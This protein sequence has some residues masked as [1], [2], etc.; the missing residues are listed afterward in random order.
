MGLS[1]LDQLLLAPLRRRRASVG[2]QAAQAQGAF[3][4]TAETELGQLGFRLAVPQ[5]RLLMPTVANSTVT[6]TSTADRTV[7]GR[8]GLAGSSLPERSPKRARI[9]YDPEERALETKS[10]GCTDTCLQ[11]AAVVQ[12]LKRRYDLLVDLSPEQKKVVLFF[13]VSQF[14][15][16]DTNQNHVQYR[17]D[18]F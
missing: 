9:A 18:L 12:V 2:V 15:R 17:C 4:P 11:Q 10:C 3:A 16:K 14:P 5:R 13:E 7:E 8:R 6:C 1:P